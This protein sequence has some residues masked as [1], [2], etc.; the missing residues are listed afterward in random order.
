MPH[1]DTL[2]LDRPQPD[3]KIPHTGDAI[4]QGLE[5]E[6]LSVN[7]CVLHAESQLGC[8]LAGYA[9][10]L[11]SPV[12]PPDGLGPGSEAADR[13]AGR[14]GNPAAEQL[15]GKSPHPFP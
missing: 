2:V 4:V 15:A 11:C 10:P 9:V 5:R 7:C 13:P 12:T 14:T 1:R 8:C 3:Q 6:G